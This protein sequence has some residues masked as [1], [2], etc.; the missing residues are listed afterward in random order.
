MIARA[1]ARSDYLP[2]ADEI[3][4]HCVRAHKSLYVKKVRKNAR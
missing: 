1:G 4:R 3:A 2:H